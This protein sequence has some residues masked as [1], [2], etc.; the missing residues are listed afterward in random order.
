VTGARRILIVSYFYPPLRSVGVRR[1]AALAKYLARAGHAVTVLTSRANGSGAVEDAE[2]TKV[3]RTG[4][5]L[6]TRLNWRRDRQR[7]AT[8]RDQATW[9]PGGNVWGSIVVPDLQLVT[10]IPSALRQAIRIVREKR[11]DV[12]IT[13]SPTESTHLIGLA[14]R[15][16][17]VPWIA[18]L[19]DGWRFESAR[20]EWPVGLQR[21]ID[22]RLEATVARRADSVVCVTRPIAEDLI[23]RHGARTDVITNGFDP[24][25][26][27][28]A[29]TALELLSER[30]HSIVH[31]GGL[32]PRR[33]IE[34]LLAGAAAL[35]AQGIAIDDRLEI[36]LAGALTAEE[37]QRFAKPDAAR[38][39]RYVGYLDR[40][41]VLALQRDADTL[42][43]V[44]SAGHAGEATGKLYEYIASGRPIL[45]LGP[46][47][48]AARIV[49]EAGVGR[50]LAR[51]ARAASDALL[52]LLDGGLPFPRSEAT[53]R[54][55]YPAL[56]GRYEELIEQTLSS[57]R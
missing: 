40:E 52:A 20:P 22:A 25:D 53:A 45:V 50:A 31:T 6:A 21:R 42:L 9:H 35:R 17:G 39:V 56:V 32:G 38:L 8:D 51:D 44:T 15:R 57:R 7:T 47:S 13:T 4:D 18:D 37:R 30:R 54:Y 23:R 3:I 28:A 1:P 43:S 10:W 27:L 55:R 34:P 16:H 29:S 11:P 14:L 24:D 5:L 12:V 36:V 46:E 19:R 41:Q 26:A 48:E 2:G 49:T 33:S